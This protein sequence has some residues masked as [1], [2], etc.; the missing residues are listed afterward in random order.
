MYRVISCFWVRGYCP[1]Y[2][3]LTTAASELASPEQ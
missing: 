1:M 3:T 2:W